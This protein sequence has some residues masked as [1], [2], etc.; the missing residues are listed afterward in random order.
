MNK[1]ELDIPPYAYSLHPFEYLGLVETVNANMLGTHRNV[2]ANFTTAADQTI[3]TVG[4]DGK[5]E[6]HAQ[7]KTEFAILQVG[8]DPYRTADAI[9]RHL[10]DRLYDTHYE[11]GPNGTIDVKDLADDETP[12]SWAFGLSRLIYPDRVLN[13]TWVMGNRHTFEE[14]RRKVLEEM[15]QESRIRR[16]LATQLKSYKRAMREGIFH[17]TPAFSLSDHVQFYS[18]LPPITAGFKSSFLRAV[19]RKLDLTTGRLIRDGKLTAHDAA[20][21]LP[22]TTTGRLQFLA[23]QGFLAPAQSEEVQEA[24]GWF[25]REYHHAQEVYKS[26]RTLVAVPFAVSEFETYAQHIY[27]FAN[28]PY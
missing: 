22:A 24:Y 13:A 8:P 18:E 5:L 16:T 15:G 6:R 4:S 20:R 19:Q 21:T 3:I 1:P 28:L 17:H 26:K 10:Q 12:L 2:L 14:A 27:T 7:S 11:V 23:D 25:L 9:A